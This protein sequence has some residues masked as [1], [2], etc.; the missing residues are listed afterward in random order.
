MMK[1]RKSAV[2][3]DNFKK[4]EDANAFPPCSA[5]A[6]QKPRVDPKYLFKI[7]EWK[8]KKKIQDIQNHH[9]SA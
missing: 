7:N 8:E 1:S 4:S 9:N 6:L 5:L 2:T 3:D